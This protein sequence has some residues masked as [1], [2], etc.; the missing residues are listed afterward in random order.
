M[1]VTRDFKCC[2]GCPWCA[3]GCCIYPI[4]VKDKFGQKLGMTRQ[5]NYWC[6]PHM[7]I[8][9]ESDT[10][11][12]EITGPCCPCQ[13]PCCKGDVDY[14]IIN[15]QTRSQVGTIKKV[16]TDVLR[17][18]FTDVTTFS[19]LFPLDLDVKHKAL[20]LAAVFLVDFSIFEQYNKGDS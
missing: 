4:Y 13:T 18:C 19:L 1:T 3:D 2:A 15:S 6:T 5:L 17:E 11:I 10:L 20:M 14:P 8:F 9:D 16:W 12:Y 7:G